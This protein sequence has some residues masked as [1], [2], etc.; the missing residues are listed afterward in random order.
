M[1]CGNI[2]MEI[3][4]KV[5]SEICNCQYEELKRCWGSEKGISHNRVCPRFKIVE[6]FQESSKTPDKIRAKKISKNCLTN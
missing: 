3:K 1:F 6:N 2:S 4:Q 5:L